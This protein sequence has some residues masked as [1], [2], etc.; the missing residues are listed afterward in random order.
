[1]GVFLVAGFYILEH[2]RVQSIREVAFA[3]NPYP[4]IALIAVVVVVVSLLNR[5]FQLKADIKGDSRSREILDIDPLNRS[6]DKLN[7]PDPVDMFRIEIK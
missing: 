4:R 1:M 3:R 2:P 5:Q 7:R 6:I